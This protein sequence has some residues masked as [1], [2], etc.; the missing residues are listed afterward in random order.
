MPLGEPAAWSGAFHVAEAGSVLPSAEE[1]KAAVDGNGYCGI[2]L[3]SFMPSFEHGVRKRFG[4]PTA[5]ET[6]VFICAVL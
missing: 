5:I 1:R 4:T 2:L 6:F 3:G